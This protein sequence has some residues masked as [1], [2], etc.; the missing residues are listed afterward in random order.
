[1]PLILV[2][3]I[4]VL[5]FGIGAILGAPYLPILHR[6]SERLLKLAGLKPGQTL[7]DLGSGDGRLLRAAAAQGIRCVGYEIN[8][9]LV[10]ISRLVCWRYHHLVTIRTA[11]FWH[12]KLPPADAI[13]VFALD[14]YMPRLDMKFTAEITRP[15]KVVSYIFTIPTR[16]PIHSTS[17]TYI[18]EYGRND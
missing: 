17:N 1:M 16:Q 2:L 8:P 9:Y 3:L 5:P 4:I 7:V 10:L 12:I 18:Y 15:T 14:K 6:D 13:Y 11:D